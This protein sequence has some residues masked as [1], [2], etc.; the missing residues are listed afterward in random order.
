MTEEDRTLFC[1]AEFEAVVAGRYPTV[2]EIR[3]SAEMPESLEKYRCVV[4]SSPPVDVGVDIPLYSLGPTAPDEMSA[5]IV[6]RLY[7]N[8]HSYYQEIERS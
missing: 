5:A 2:E 3:A 1:S 7:R 8:R 6:R 4:S